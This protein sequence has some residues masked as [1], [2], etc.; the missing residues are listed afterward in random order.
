MSRDETTNQIH[1]GRSVIAYSD[2]KLLV[3]RR[4]LEQSRE[5][6]DDPSGRVWRL[7]VD[8]QAFDIDLRHHPA[9]APLAKHVDALSRRLDYVTRTR[10]DLASFIKSMA[11]R[12]AME[13]AL[14]TPSASARLTM[15]AMDDVRVEHIPVPP[16]GRLMS[17]SVEDLY[18]H[19]GNGL[20]P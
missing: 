17:M 8:V 1:R 10:R 11:R 7:L 20:S 9:T 18:K 5:V 13:Q 4:I 2:C 12:H 3:T 19:I 16:V 14:A 15:L 6:V